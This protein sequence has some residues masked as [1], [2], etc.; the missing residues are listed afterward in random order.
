M[1]E[2]LN[3]IK[4]R[5]SVRKFLTTP[6]EEDKVEAILTAGQWAPS[7]V[8]LQP[9]KF[10]VV[11]DPETKK[12]LAEILKMPMVGIIYRGEIAYDQLP[13]VPVIIVVVVDP[14]KD[15]LHYVEDGAV[16]TQNMALAAHSL[17]LGTYWIGVYNHTY[18]EDEIKKALEIPVDCRVISLMPVGVAAETPQKDRESLGNIVYY[19]KFG[20]R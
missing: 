3:T 13:H 20:K 6:I 4:N 1:S 16:A 17:G 8:N 2:V 5:R 11:R 9:W 19:D 12:K 18:I 14:N 15:K 10:I 7:F